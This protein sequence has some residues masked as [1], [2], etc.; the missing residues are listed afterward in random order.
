[1]DNYFEKLDTSKMSEDELDDHDEELAKY[2]SNPEDFVV[3]EAKDP[4]TLRSLPY[5]IGS[6]FYLE[7]EHIGLEE[8]LSEEEEADSD[9]D[10]QLK[11]IEANKETDDDGEESETETESDV[12]SD[13]DDIK[14]ARA[15]PSLEFTTPSK[16]EKA[17]KVKA[18]KKSNMFS[19]STEESEQDEESGAENENLFSS[20][21]VNV[22]KILFFFFSN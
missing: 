21:K 1:M 7:N 11:K 8:N 14:P 9:Y 13:T 20:K 3:Y 5:L 16:Q 22:Q 17:K 18:V 4:Y 12:Q 15:A 10:E 2:Q 6:S 19:S